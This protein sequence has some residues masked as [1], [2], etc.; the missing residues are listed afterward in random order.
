MKTL[1]ILVPVYNTEKYIQRC[2]DSI[3]IEEVLDDIEVILVNDGSKDNSLRILNEYKKKHPNSVI[4][5]DKENGGH[6]ST[7]NAG[8]K[9]ASG[10]YFRVVDSDDWVKSTD[11]ISFVKNLKNEDVDLIVTN[12]KKEFI[13][14]STSESIEWK[15]LKENITYNFNE[16]NLELLEKDYFVMANSTY[17]T[18]ILRQSN[19]KLLENTFYVDMQY[20]VVPILNIKTFKFFKLDIYRYFIGRPEQSMNLQNFVRNRSDHEKVMKFLLE[21]YKEN[22]TQ[23]SKNQ[24]A[25]IKLI[26]FYMLTTHYYI[27]CVYPKKSEKDI[28]ETIK[29]FDSYLKNI[30]LELYNE[31]YKIAQIKYNRKFNFLFVKINPKKFSSFITLCG[32]IQRRMKGE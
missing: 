10:K 5:I 9:I 1:S 14:N 22:I 19:L 30:N 24:D 2:L 31:M 7:I 3:L 4:V 6:G 29:K 8:L 25:Y 16:F 15:K 32:K 28:Y 26:L 13:F 23:L 20:N 21:F 11:F 18:E 27:Y 12:Y 17:R